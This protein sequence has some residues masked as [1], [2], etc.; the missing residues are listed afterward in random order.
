MDSVMTSM[1]SM[2]MIFK[3]ENQVF[4]EGRKR[5]PAN[6]MVHCPWKNSQIWSAS[7]ELK[8]REKNSRKQMSEI[9]IEM[10]I[11]L[12]VIIVFHQ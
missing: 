9:V 4:Q 7:K 8:L 11:M 5:E 2:L 1:V 6:Q 12:Y 10:Y 3:E